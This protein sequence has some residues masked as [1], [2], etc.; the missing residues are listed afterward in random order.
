LSETKAI[1]IAPRRWRRVAIELS[2]I[3]DSCERA[4]KYRA[5]W[6]VWWE[7]T[8]HALWSP[9]HVTTRAAALASRHGGSW[10]ECESIDQAGAMMGVMKFDDCGWMEDDGGRKEGGWQGTKTSTKVVGPMAEFRVA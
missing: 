8:A 10:D 6:V 5:T 7:D 4:S 3:G 9:G 1:I 2:A